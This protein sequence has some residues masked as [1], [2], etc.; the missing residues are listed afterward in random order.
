MKY[1]YFISSTKKFRH[2]D[3]RYLNIVATCQKLTN[4]Q[5]YKKVP[6]SFDYIIRVP[7]TRGHRLLYLGR[8]DDGSLYQFNG[9]DAFFRSD[10]FGR[11]QIEH[12]NRFGSG[13]TK[14]GTATDVFG[15]LQG[16]QNEHE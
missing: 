10:A 8:F 3:A 1:L 15:L 14:T 4:L 5:G 7:Y 6:T 13:V 2:C 12:G 16:K 11:N 9:R